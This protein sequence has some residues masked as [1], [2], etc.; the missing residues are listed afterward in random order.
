MVWKALKLNS[1]A[2]LSP[3][4]ELGRIREPKG[5]P[6]EL[7]PRTDG[8]FWNPL[9]SLA[10]QT[11]VCLSPFLKLFFIFFARTW[12]WPR[13]AQSMRNHSALVGN[14]NVILVAGESPRA[15]KSGFNSGHLQSERRILCQ[16]LVELDTKKN[17]KFKNEKNLNRKIK[18]SELCSVWFKEERNL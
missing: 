3:L 17:K 6:R 16:E 1:Q 12:A 18:T 13:R 14:K 5:A 11:G 8:D 4:E 7:I 10:E 15:G 2:W 9:Q